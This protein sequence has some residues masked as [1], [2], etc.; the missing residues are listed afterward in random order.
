MDLS[1]PS[2]LSHSGRDWKISRTRAVIRATSTPFRQVDDQRRISRWLILTAEDHVGPTLEQ[3]ATRR[4]GRF[5][6]L[7]FRQG[8]LSH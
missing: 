8:H 2:T 5:R 6:R 7:I 3:P 4:R 1:G